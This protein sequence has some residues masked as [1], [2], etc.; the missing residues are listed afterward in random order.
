MSQTEAN[1]LTVPAPGT[2]TIDPGRSSIAFR[3]RHVFGLAGVDGS[4]SV[5]S[6][7]IRVADEAA[8]SGATAVIDANSFTTGNGTRDDVVR[9]DK[10]LATAT[11]P[12]ITFT[13]DAV[14]EAQGSYTLHGELTVRATTRPVELLI[15]QSRSGPDGISFRA[16]TKIDRYAFGITADKGMTARYLILTLDVVASPA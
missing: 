15:E 12:H 14:R 7:Q 10:Y 8:E 11:H 2:Y 5:L 4:F 6:G 13:S 9:S 3:T 1:A 16:T